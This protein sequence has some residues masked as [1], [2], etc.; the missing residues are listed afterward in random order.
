MGDTDSRT[1]KQGAGYGS[2][3]LVASKDWFGGACG[4]D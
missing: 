1:K 4:R 3:E 2:V